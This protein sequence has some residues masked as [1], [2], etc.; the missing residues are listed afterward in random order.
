MYKMDLSNQRILV[1]GATGFLGGRLVEKLVLENH[2]QVRVII[3]N[4][5]KA[6]RIARFPIEMVR[7]DISNLEDVKA[8][9]KDCDIVIHCAWDYGFERD[10]AE[11]RKN[12][13]EG[14]KNI[15]HTSKIQGVKRVVFVSTVAV[16]SYQKEGNITEDISYCNTREV[17][18]DTKIQCEE[19]VKS[20][21]QKGLPV[22]IVQPTVIYGPWSDIWT[23]FP[24]RRLKDGYFVLDD[25]EGLCNAVYIDDVVHGIVLAAVKAEAIGETFLISGEKPVRWREFYG[26]YEKM[27]K[28]DSLIYKD[29][30]KLKVNI[31]WQ[32]I[33]DSKIGKL[34]M[35]IRQVLRKFPSVLKGYLSFKETV[36]RVEIQKENSNK[37]IW[38]P[39]EIFFKLFQAK[40]TVKIDKAKRLLDYQPAFDLK[41]GMVMT[42]VWAKWVNLL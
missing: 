16:Y 4:F 2:A 9:L 13:L 29:P 26:A 14:L 10:K 1:T 19:I 38:M 34:L 20:F 35:P 22:V 30:K 12:N 32:K 27:L 42:E 17:Y 6:A 37:S 31:R 23:T 28:V 8:A 11:V 41:R 40:T 39:S 3:R 7:G 24:L 18:A 25:G 5:N 21:G 33:L 36:V 15:L